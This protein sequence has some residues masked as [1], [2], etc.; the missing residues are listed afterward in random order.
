MVG[1]I[2]NWLVK[3]VADQH[4]MSDAELQEEKHRADDTHLHAADIEAIADEASHNKKVLLAWLAVG[5]P[6]LWGVWMTLQ[7]AFVLFK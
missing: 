2:C 6:L 1:F 4:Y 5:I 7:K 3:P